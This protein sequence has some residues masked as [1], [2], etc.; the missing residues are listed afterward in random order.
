MVKLDISPEARND[1]LEIK[2]YITEEFDSPSA[3]INTVAKITKAIRRLT[4]FPEMGAPLSSIVDLQ[5]DYRFIVCGNYLVFY[6]HKGGAVTVIRIVYG[7]RD[8]MKFLFGD[9]P[10]SRLD[11]EE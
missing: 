9:A 3:A 10:D 8:Y 1:L 11:T 6:G 2:K 5:T 4:H 7:K